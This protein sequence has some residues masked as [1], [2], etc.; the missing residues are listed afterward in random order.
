MVR[1]EFTADAGCA[2]IK[3]IELLW[4]V[5]G[6]ARFCWVKSVNPPGSRRDIAEGR[7][8]EGDLESEGGWM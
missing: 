6:G 5:S 2:W 1:E 3:A 7:N 4:C 8:I